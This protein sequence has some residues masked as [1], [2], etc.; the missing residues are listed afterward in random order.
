MVLDY[1]PWL[2]KRAYNHAYAHGMIKAL[3]DENC[4]A[5]R[6][7]VFNGDHFLMYCE[8]RRQIKD[9]LHQMEEKQKEIK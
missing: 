9:V 7:I 1:V 4:H 6:K 2:E 3:V 5:S 8:L